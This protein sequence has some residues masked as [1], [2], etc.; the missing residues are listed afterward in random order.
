VDGYDRKR[1]LVID[2]ALVYCSY[3]GGSGADQI[4]AVEVDSQGHL[5][6]TGTT[7][8]GDLLATNDAYS[9]SIVSQTC[10]FVAIVDITPGSGFPM[11]YFTYIGGGGADIPLAMAVDSQENVYLTGTT[12]STSFPHYRQCRANHGRRQRGVRLRARAESVW[13]GRR[14]F[15][16]LFDFSGRHHRGYG[17]QWHCRGSQGA[18]LRHRQHQGHRLPAHRQRPTW[19]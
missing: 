14:R 10:I 11:L 4:N 6:V 1:P 7:N 13:R 2:P 9:T 19:P 8:T 16:G 18:D 3:L 5:Y 15:P 12:D 17:R